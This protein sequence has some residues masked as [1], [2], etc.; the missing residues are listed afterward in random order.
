MKHKSRLPKGIG[1]VWHAP[2]KRRLAKFEIVYRTRPY[3][4]KSSMLALKSEFAGTPAEAKN[5][6]KILKADQTAKDIEIVK[7]KKSEWF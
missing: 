4:G 5:W 2:K 1:A 7:L 6:V 3:G